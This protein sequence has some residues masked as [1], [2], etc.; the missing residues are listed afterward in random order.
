MVA[1]QGLEATHAVI[2]SAHIMENSYTRCP[3]C[4]VLLGVDKVREETQ[5]VVHDMGGQKRSLFRSP[6]SLAMKV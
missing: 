6:T 3:K 4:F 1:S 2:H 5:Q